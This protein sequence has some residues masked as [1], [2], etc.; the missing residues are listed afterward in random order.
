MP[1]TKADTHSLLFG[2]LLGEQF[3]FKAAADLLVENKIIRDLLSWLEIA[4]CC[5]FTVEH[6]KLAM[7][8]TTLFL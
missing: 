3:I 8:C 5:D 1:G 2:S 7:R 4:C 6:M